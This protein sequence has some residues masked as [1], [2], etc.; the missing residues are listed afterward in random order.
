MNVSDAIQS[1]RSTRYFDSDHKLSEQDLDRLLSA[2]MLAPS[3]FNMQNR[4]VVAVVDQGVKDRM[5]A[6]AWDQEHVSSASVVLVFAGRLQAWRDTDR[7]LRDAPA[8]ARATFDPM[9][10]AFYEGKDAL[11]REEACRTVGLAAMSAMLTARELGLDSCPMIGFDPVQ[12]SEILGLDADHPP[13]MLVAVGK[14][15]AEPH[16]RLG[17]LDREEVVSLDHFDNRAFTGSI[18]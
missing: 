13:L 10:P 17:L 18:E 5:R 11:L 2:V 1:R 7:Y 14:A 6:A 9:I 3:S 4:H 8:E 15:T 16:P 12:V